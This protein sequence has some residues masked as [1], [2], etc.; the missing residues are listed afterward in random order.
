MVIVVIKDFSSTTIRNTQVIA[1][2]RGIDRPGLV[3]G[4]DGPGLVRGVD[5]PGLVRGVDRPGFW[6]DNISVIK[7]TG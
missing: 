2:V 1:L 5:R 4:V 6:L 7:K 3:I